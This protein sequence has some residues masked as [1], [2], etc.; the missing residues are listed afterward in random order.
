MFGNGRPGWF[1]AGCAFSL[2]V[3]YFEKERAA[4]FKK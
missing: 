1:L 4:E 3:A 2:V